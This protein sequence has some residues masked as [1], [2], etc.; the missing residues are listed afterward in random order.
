MR[1]DLPLTAQEQQNVLLY[2]FLCSLMS[3][4][5]GLILASVSGTP[6]NQSCAWAVDAL[7]KT[8]QIFF[9]QIQPCIMLSAG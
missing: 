2:F 6:F 1:A 8:R 5:Y 7:Q 4:I 3:P 9:P